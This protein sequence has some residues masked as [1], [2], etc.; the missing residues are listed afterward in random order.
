MVTASSLVALGIVACSS[1]SADDR[2]EVADGAPLAPDGADGGGGN[3]DGSAP[4]DSGPDAQPSG[5]AGFPDASSCEDFDGLDPFAKWAAKGYF[6][7]GAVGVVDGGSVDR[8]EGGLSAPFAMGTFVGVAPDIGGAFLE[9]HWTAAHHVRVRGAFAIP[10]AADYVF[11]ITE[12]AFL[13]S[14]A[15]G[16]LFSARV[17][18]HP[19][20]KLLKVSIVDAASGTS[21]SD[22]ALNGVDFAGWTA[23]D[24]DFAF[25][26]TFSATARIGS[27]VVTAPTSTAPAAASANVTVQAGTTQAVTATGDTRVLVDDLVVWSE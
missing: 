3:G 5:C 10:A 6:D 7:G 20:T 2:S 17:S 1:F 8:V 24:L 11:L 23:L 26:P 27:K 4:A 22:V 21:L 19:K 18:A 15:G 14:D 12:T 9:Q 13:A 16:Q 25:T